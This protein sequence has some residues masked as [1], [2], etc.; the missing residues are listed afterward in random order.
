[1]HCVA[2]DACC[3]MMIIS[4]FKNTYMEGIHLSPEQ[5][6][7]L[8]TYL[9]QQ[10]AERKSIGMLIAAVNQI[11]ISDGVGEVLLK[12]GFKDLTGP[13]FHPGHGHRITL[14]GYE[15]FPEKRQK[16]A[17]WDFLRRTLKK[18]YKGKVPKEKVKKRVFG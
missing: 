18:T 9:K 12:C 11:Q 13:F 2:F 3:G 5:R 8:A 1:M 17:P 14:F 6:N 16:P 7:A 4:R 15:Q 10:I